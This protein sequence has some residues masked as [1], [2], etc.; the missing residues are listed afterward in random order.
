MTIMSPD[1]KDNIPGQNP[2]PDVEKGLVEEDEE[3]AEDEEIVDDEDD[4][5][6]KEKA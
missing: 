4:Q 3:I 2:M 6:K 5:D 1:P